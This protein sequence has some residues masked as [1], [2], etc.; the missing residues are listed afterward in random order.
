M[1]G[2]FDTR[3]QFARGLRKHGIPLQIDRFAAAEA[4]LSG[5]LGVAREMR[6]TGATVR[7]VLVRLQ[8]SARNAVHGLEQP[9]GAAVD[10]GARLSAV[11]GEKLALIF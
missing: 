5:Q 9:A 7:A 3:F 11:Y 4:P 8:R 1:Y 6:H 10:R 2:I